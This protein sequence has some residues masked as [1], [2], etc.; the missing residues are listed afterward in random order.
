MLL[1]TNK[2]KKYYYYL[3]FSIT[4]TKKLS[5]LHIH[6]NKNTH[7]HIKN[8]CSSLTDDSLLIKEK[9]KKK[10]KKKCDLNLIN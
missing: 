1:E 2:Y 4:T 7:S 3:F 10:K 9:I 6:T 5:K 8:H